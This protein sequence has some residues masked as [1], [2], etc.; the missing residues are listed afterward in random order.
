MALPL[1]HGEDVQ[2]MLDG[3]G[4]VPVTIGGATARCLVDDTDEVVA[5]SLNT[6]LVG[7]ALVLRAAR[8]AFPAAAQGVAATVD[9]PAPGTSYT[10]VLV[11]REINTAVIAVA[12]V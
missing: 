11:R 3:A 6:T 2:L 1:W 9:Y 7:R 10:V 4:G 8:D 12:K 5:T